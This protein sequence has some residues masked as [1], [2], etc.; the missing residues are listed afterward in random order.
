ML[1]A[2]ECAGEK[3]RI[4]LRWSE[5][6][7]ESPECQT[8]KEMW[9]ISRCCG[10]RWWRTMLENDAGEIKNTVKW[11]AECRLILEESN[12]HSKHRLSS[13]VGLSLHCSLSRSI[14]ESP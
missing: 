4:A 5:R 3:L 14:Q 8:A 1:F 7:T 13:I 9:R 10:G 6:S 2:F 11:S 12:W